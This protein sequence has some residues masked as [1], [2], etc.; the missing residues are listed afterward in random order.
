MKRSQVVGGLVTNPDFM[1]LWASHS[2]SALGSSVTS[3]ALPLTAILLYDATPFQMGLI[4]ALHLLPR[5]LVSLYFGTLVDR[6]RKRSLMVSVQIIR[7]I[8]YGS[9][10][11]LAFLDYLNIGY[12]YC[13]AFTSGIL[14]L[15]FQFADRAYLA[16][17]VSR[18]EILEGNAKMQFSSSV[19]QTVGPSLGGTLVQ[20]ITAPM[21][22]AVDAISFFISAI[23][24]DRIEKEESDPIPINDDK[25]WWLDVKEGAIL[26]LNNIVLRRDIISTFFATAGS[27]II[28]AVLMLYLVRDLEM[29]PV[30]VGT[31][32]SIGSIASILGS[33]ASTTIGK[34]FGIGRAVIFGT[35]FPGIA[36][37]LYPVAD[38]LFLPTLLV[39][40]IARFF[41]DFWVPVYVANE[42]TIRQSAAP[43]SFV[44]RVTSLRVFMGG[45]IGPLGALTGGIKGEMF[46]LRVTIMI[47]AAIF[48]CS[49]FFLA[50]LAQYSIHR[51]TEASETRSVFRNG[52]LTKNWSG[53]Q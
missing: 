32:F 26:V 51:P 50:P 15:L 48:F 42:I 18:E 20:L 19:T 36:Y 39:L 14:V 29:T 34:R 47:G 21:A 13:V 2:T 43:R 35:L 16:R 27:T 33:I 25:P 23:L 41:L 31:L 11:I 45:G 8:L 49:V 38:Q 22:I 3:V 12:L 53:R 4:S 10:P 5:L 6:I 28:S 7:G 24:L 37:L 52:R 1:K 44:G 17:L 30:L 9:I 40:I 46:G